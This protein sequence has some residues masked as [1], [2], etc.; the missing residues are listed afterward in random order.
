MV[1]ASIQEDGINIMRGMD[2][3]IQ[4][5]PFKTYERDLEAMSRR[6][7]NSG[8]LSEA[9]QEIPY[10]PT[11][12]GSMLLVGEE[13]GE[14]VRFLQS[15]RDFME[16][17]NS[18]RLAQTVNILEPMVIGVLGFCMA[19]VCIGMFLPIYSILGSL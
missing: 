3:L 17:Q 8:S 18:M 16:L 5:A 6:L 1:L 2:I 19:F 9:V 10:F 11:V 14:I 7:Q 4:S 13:S 15:A 12:V